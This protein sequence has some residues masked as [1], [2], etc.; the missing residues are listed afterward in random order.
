MSETV[1]FSSAQLA[2]LNR[3]GETVDPERV[4][5]LLEGLDERE[6]GKVLPYALYR[7]AQIRGRELAPW[8]IWA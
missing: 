8:A 1:F 7:R 3:I 6:R 4:K 2:A 5:A